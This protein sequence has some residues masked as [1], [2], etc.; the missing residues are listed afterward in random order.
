[1]VTTRFWRTVCPAHSQLPVAFFALLLLLPVDCSERTEDMSE[2]REI[3]QSLYQNPSV[4]YRPLDLV[5]VLDRSA[6]VSRAGWDAMLRFVSSLLEHFTVDPNNTRVAVITYATFA[7]IDIDGIRTG[8]HTKCSLNARL[9]RHTLRKVPGGY[10]AAHSALMLAASILVDS[11]RDSRK[12]VIVVTDGKSNIGPPPVRAAVYLRSLVWD[13]QW[14]TTSDGPQLQLYAFGVRHAY[15]PE[16]RS[17]AWPQT[18][19]SF[20]VPDFRHFAMLARSLH[21]DE[22]TETWRVAGQGSLCG[23]LCHEQAICACATRQGRYT[24][25]CKEGYQGDGITCTACPRGTY[26]GGVS[27]SRCASCPAN[28]STQHE[29]AIAVSQCVCRPSLY[30]EAPGEPCHARKCPPL[31]DI[32]HGHSFHV[33]GRVYDELPDT[34]RPCLN[35]PDSSCHFRCDVGFRLDGHP[36]LVCFPNGSWVGSVPQCQV[37]DC[38]QLEYHNQFSSRGRVEYLNDSTTYESQVEV[39]CLTGWRLFGDSRRTCASTGLWSGTQAW[40]VETL[41]PALHVSPGLTISPSTCSHSR[42]TPGSLC[43]MSCGTGYRQDGPASVRCL[44]TGQWSPPTPGI[45]TD[46]ESPQI[47]CPEDISTPITSANFALVHWDSPP[48]QASDNSGHVTVHVL[49]VVE[50]PVRL[51]VGYHQLQYVARDMAG[52]EAHCTRGV[53]VTDFTV[54]LVTCPEAAITQE[55]TSHQ[56]TATWPEVVF[57]DH[58]NVTVPHTCT[59]ENGSLLPAGEYTVTCSPADIRH[60][61]AV[62]QFRLLLTR[63]E[64]KI[65]S[66]PHRG[67][68][69]C[70]PTPTSLQTCVPHCR[71][72]YAFHQV[73]QNVYVCDLNGRWRLRHGTFWPDCS[74][75]YFP[76]KAELRGRAKFYFEG[77]DCVSARAEIAEMF[78]NTL[79]DLSWEVCGDETCNVEDVIVYC[80]TDSKKKRRRR[81]VQRKPRGLTI[82][83]GI[84]KNT[85]SL[86]F[87]SKEEI[88]S[89]KQEIRNQRK[90]FQFFTKEIRNKLDD[91]IDR[92]TPSSVLF[93]S[94]TSFKARVKR[95]DPFSSR[96]ELQDM[97]TPFQ[98][99]S[100]QRNRGA[101]HSETSA[102]RPEKDTDSVDKGPDEKEIKRDLFYMS[103]DAFEKSG[104]TPDMQA[105]HQS[106]TKGYLSDDGKRP[107]QSASNKY[108]E[109]RSWRSADTAREYI[110]TTTPSS[111][112]LNMNPFVQFLGFSSTT[113]T[114]D[115]PANSNVEGTTAPSSLEPFPQNSTVNDQNGTTNFPANSSQ[116]SSNEEESDTLPWKLFDEMDNSNNTSNS[117]PWDSWLAKDIDRGASGANT[118]TSQVEIEFLIQASLAADN[119]TASSQYTLLNTLADVQ[120]SLTIKWDSSFSNE[121]QQDGDRQSDNGT[122]VSSGGLSFDMPEVISC[123]SGHVTQIDLMNQIQTCVACPA[124]SRYD[125]EDDRCITCQIGE[126]QP[127][128]AQMNCL[129]CPANTTTVNH[130]AVNSSQCAALCSPGEFSSSGLAPCQ[131]CPR[132]SYQ[133]FRSASACLRCPAGRHTQ[134]PGA[135][136]RSQCLHLCGPGNYSET[137]LVP[138]QPCPRGSYQPEAGATE[139]YLCEGTETTEGEGVTNSSAC[140]AQYVCNDTFCEHGGQCVL[141]NETAWCVCQAGYTGA[142]CEESVDNCLGQPCLNLGSCQN[143]VSGFSCLCTPGFSGPTCEVD[144]DECMSSPCQNGGSCLDQATGYSCFCPA[145]WTGAHCEVEVKVCTEVTCVHGSCEE[146]D[147]SP[148]CVCSPGYAG[149]SCNVTFDLCSSH[150]CMHAGACNTLIGGF[151]CLCLPGFIGSLCETQINP[152][153]SNP[154]SEGSTCINAQL[155]YLCKCPAGRSGVSCDEEVSP[156]YDLVFQPRAPDGQFVSLPPELM[157]DL[158]SMTLCAWFRPLPLAA[159]A[160]LVTFNLL[161]TPNLNPSWR[162]DGGP[163]D[164]DVTFAIRHTDQIMVQIFDEEKMTNVSLPPFTWSH[165]CAI[166]DSGEDAW[167][168]FLNGSSVAAGGLDLP[169]PLIPGDTSVVLGQRNPYHRDQA[170][171]VYEGEITQLN[172]YGRVLTSPEIRSIAGTC[173]PTPGD[174]IAWTQFLPYIRGDLVIREGSHCQDVNECFFPE[175]FPCGSRQCLDLLGSYVCSECLQGYSGPNCDEPE[176]ECLSDVCAEG[177]TCVDGPEPL[178]FQCFCPAGFTGLLCEIRI[179]LCESAPCQNGGTCTPAVNDFSCAC[180]DQLMGPLCEHP[181]SSCLPNPCQHRGVC[182]EENGVHFRC[183]CADD[184]TG[185]FCQ[186]K[187]S[188]CQ[189]NP[190][191]NG[192]SCVEVTSFANDNQILP[193][194][195]NYV[196][197]CEHGWTGDRCEVRV[198]PSCDLSPCVNG[199][200]CLPSPSG[201][202][203]VCQD[204]R[205]IQWDENCEV[206]NPCLSQT[207]PNNTV[208]V[209]LANHTAQCQCPHA[210]ECPEWTVLPSGGE[211]D[212]SKIDDNTPQRDSGVLPVWA[213]VAISCACI[214]LLC[215]PVMIFCLR[216][217]AKTRAKQVA[218]TIDTDLSMDHVTNHGF[219][220]DE[221]RIEESTYAELSDDCSWPQLDTIRQLPRTGDSSMAHASASTSARKVSSTSSGSF[222]SLRSS[223]SRA[224]SSRRDETS[225]LLL[226]EHGKGEGE[227]NLGFD[228]EDDYLV[229]EPATKRRGNNAMT[230][231]SMTPMHDGKLDEDNKPE[232]I[233]HKAA[234]HNVYVN[235]QSRDS[236]PQGVE[237]LKEQENKGGFQMVENPGYIPTGDVARI[238]PGLNTAT[239]VGISSLP[240]DTY[241][242]NPA[243]AQRSGPVTGDYVNEISNRGSFSS[244]VTVEGRSKGE[245]SP[246]PGSPQGSSQEQNPSLRPPPTKGAGSSAIHSS[247][248]PFTDKITLN[249]VKE[250]SEVPN[251]SPPAIGSALMGVKPSIPYPLR[252]QVSRGQERNS[253]PPTTGVQAKSMPYVELGATNQHSLQHG[254]SS[255]QF[256][257]EYLELSNAQNPP[258]DYSKPET[259]PPLHGKGKTNLRQLNVASDTLTGRSTGASPFLSKE[260]KATSTIGVLEDFTSNLPKIDKAESK[261][262]YKPKP[263]PKVEIHD[264]HRE[265]KSGDRGRGDALTSHNA[266]RSA[267]GLTR[268]EDHITGGHK[269]G[270]SQTDLGGAGVIKDAGNT[271][272]RGGKLATGTWRNNGQRS[273]RKQNT[274][275]SSGVAQTRSL[276]P[277]PSDTD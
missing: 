100:D 249:T 122:L 116:N 242:I 213:T 142:R 93:P 171:E 31:Q 152:C 247:Y 190:C 40:C 102:G 96:R 269:S 65:P 74:R 276:P 186:D 68:V 230:E 30:R 80:G 265:G 160:S 81:E 60:R 43:E 14:N 84:F 138:C 72:G 92:E 121:T 110:D 223:V 22:Q 47:T 51:T 198:E 52:N 200:T 37:V 193:A 211:G 12:A 32:D 240:F 64:C 251:T 127:Q 244:G 46:L 151:E 172:V 41:C 129:E 133:P 207:C 15:M 189:R 177:A 212:V 245:P 130:G 23:G 91:H 114:G 277:L 125:P 215:L 202:T 86:R 226:H 264:F 231:T 103:D 128:A 78:R 275:Q 136:H 266:S 131:K 261:A 146:S 82:S 20:Y 182:V 229:P 203:C 34:G 124:G 71:Q 134:H 271:G 218:L 101:S 44:D 126:Y 274:S 168:V 16:V 13:P 67:S 123:R 95:F 217:R 75:R 106:P 143:E 94:T 243:R 185:S 179:D 21:D 135:V 165:L 9:E 88:S 158:T 118:S 141:V 63:P 164:F 76:H 29:A 209:W 53:T 219:Q 139:C 26:K 35:T 39:V 132:H 50:N 197:R 17:L 115:S 42:Q 156:D 155:S 38:G 255:D 232:Q 149:S 33:K 90:Q 2:G 204:R 144:I 208:C 272:P 79:Q 87:A 270:P 7:T 89:E 187:M 222:A 176:D 181:A 241:F 61:D 210:G 262:P 175:V 170:W 48:A 184:Y 192:G 109:G 150:P 36:G 105:F 221:D 117:D 111:S 120:D 99:D 205:G 25:V 18:N 273:G 235:M 19:H 73:A 163:R 11:R 174:V 180:P 246:S 220:P 4:S 145:G 24:C 162:E 196:C 194:E 45:C 199:G 239:N 183:R 154:C 233:R 10:S 260:G 58:R 256:L 97:G 263:P 98:R 1:M 191:M 107:V 237:G 248:I 238:Q 56:A 267:G 225:Q 77:G 137:G 5:F 28:S 234:V 188:W 206:L 140:T 6:S 69:S 113:A 228:P 178:D 195:Q 252:T 83:E 169:L 259:F 49:G 166:W 55:M 112:A 161:R 258:A 119:M 257:P 8:S 3:L 157:P 148:N 201:Y 27:P 108:R 57:A 254:M 70:S 159:F 268:L 253:F 153:D 59:P 214:V 85:T 224:T 236:A 216:R 250:N 54:H 147:G 167:A 227:S 173:S 66:P 62:C 104:F